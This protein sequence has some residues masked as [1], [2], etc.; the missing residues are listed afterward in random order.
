MLFNT[1]DISVQFVPSLDP[2]ILKDLIARAKPLP[3]FLF[4]INTFLIHTGEV[5]LYPIHV[6]LLPF[7]L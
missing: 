3:S 5:N 6:V 7:P 4:A 1:P 2:C